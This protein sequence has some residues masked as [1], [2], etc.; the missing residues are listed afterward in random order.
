MHGNW[1]LF[2]EVDF[3]CRKKNKPKK[4]WQLYDCQIVKWIVKDQVQIET[5][6]D[7]TKC[8]FMENLV[9]NIDI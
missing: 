3:E 7:I 6:T 9:I 2:K 8:T 4:E 1:C 5:K